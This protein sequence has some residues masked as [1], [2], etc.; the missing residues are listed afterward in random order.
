MLM[1]ESGS[2]PFFQVGR[3]TRC[4][5]GHRWRF[6]VECEIQQCERDPW[7]SLEPFGSLWLWA[8][9][10]VIGNPHRSEQLNLGFSDFY[11]LVKN[12]GTR[13]AARFNEISHAD[14]LDLVFWTRFGEDD[15]FD[16]N[17]W[18]QVD[19][20]AIRYDGLIHY[21]A[22][23][24]SSPLFDGWR[25]ILLETDD[26]DTLIWAPHGGAVNEVSVPRGLFA[27]VADQACRWFAKIRAQSIGPTLVPKNFEKPRF[28]N[29]VTPPEEEYFGL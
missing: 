13:P 29:R 14:A 8:G 20:Q 22:I 10:H 26:S 28:V 24:S 1:P 27:H 4:C 16:A 25:A 19:P 15:E 17:R 12:D 5:I 9:G 11:G 3:L 18:P 23:S 7:G 21:E 2:V 6:A